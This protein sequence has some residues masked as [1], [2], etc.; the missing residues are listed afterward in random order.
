MKYISQF[1]R[2]IGI[3]LIILT[4]VLGIFFTIIEREIANSGLEKF[5]FF[6]NRFFDLRLIGH[7]PEKKDKNIV[8]ANLDD[9][10]LKKIGTWPIPRS[11]WATFLN[12]LKTYGAKVVGFDVLFPEPAPSCSGEVSPDDIFSKAIANFQAEGDRSVIMAY[13]IE[14]HDIGTDR[15][16]EIPEE[17]FNFILDSQQSGEKGLDPRFIEKHNWPIK[18]LLE[19]TPELGYINMKEDSDGVFR[20]YPL[21]ANVD[22]LYFPSLALK[23]FES[24][25]GTTN[26]INITNSRYAT[27][28]IN[29][30]Q[31]FVN[32]AGETKIRWVGTY[33]IFDDI[34]L[35]EIMFG[36][37]N[38]KKL[39]ERLNGKIVFVGSSA[40]GAH[41]LRHSPIDSQ[42]PGVFAHMNMLHMLLEQYFFK[43]I[44]DSVKISLLFLIIGSIIIL[45][46]MAFGKAI[47]DVFVL[48]AVLYIS[49][50]IDVNY[51]LPEGYEIKLF[52]CYFSFVASYS[53]ITFL[54]FNQ[55]NAEKKQIKG[56]FARYVAP[57]IVD[58]MLDNPD[59]LKVGG[60]RRDITCL[61]SDVRD[62]TSI[63]ESLSAS[64]LASALNRY[65]G[66]MTD[67]VF[68]TN[69]TLDKYIGDAIVAFWGAPLDI[70]DHVNQSI[71]AAVK[72]LEALPAINEE[73]KANGTPEFKIGLGLNSGECNVG[74][75]GSDQIFAYTALGDNMNLGAR[76]ESLCKHY[77][78][79]I[80]V[81]EFTYERM[82][83]D[84][85]T[86]R[87]IDKVRVKGKTEPVGVYEVLYSYHPFM[88]DQES[89]AMFKDAYQDYLDMKF[90]EAK[91]KFEE[92]LKKHPEDKASLRLKASC[93]KYI[94][95][96]PT[97]DEDHTIT[98]MTE[99]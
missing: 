64:E 82:D 99:K 33:N 70:G 96:P 86:T 63:S 32:A 16:E 9:N 65:M 39:K 1:M 20:H 80:L 95:I 22:S 79:Q 36:D 48:G 87:L 5:S 75:M 51:L 46:T 8:L 23:A 31:L 71:D 50:F 68:A 92:I 13:T 38:D 53:W 47:L 57:A 54:N 76:L 90:A 4:S 77:G 11:N 84:R 3:F 27:M 26:T 12:K 61:F 83:H 56:A 93:E 58:D 37:P 6:E 94:E 42:M 19:A 24:F 97:P 55:A 21:V 73:F 40:T 29:G 81:S 78:A 91:E 43:S 52:W 66:E 74:N 98:T 59:K 44:D 85:W 30:K 28:E 67:I 69:G 45:G 18:K 72:M 41:D 2:S 17:M 34:P 25:T 49:W 60:D 62:F 15:F 35:H 88:I 14:Y 7:L 10:S 89:L